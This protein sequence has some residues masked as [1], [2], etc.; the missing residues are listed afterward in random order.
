MELLLATA[1]VGKARE[2]EQMLAADF[3][4]RAV[5]PRIEETG[6]TFTDNAILKATALSLQDRQS[7]VIADDSGLEVDSL[8]GAPGIFSARYAG[9]NASD[10]DKV[11]KLLRELGGKH[12]RR[13]RFRCVIALAR[14]GK[15]VRT[16]EGAVAGVIVDLARGTNGFGYDPV[17]QPDGC[18]KT[19]AE[20]PS[21]VK[22][23]ISHRARAIEQ[24]RACLQTARA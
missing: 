15:L 10:A 5:D 8:G 4:V 22:N 16:F 6:K 11:A 23:R 9:A 14:D 2:F 7:L 17:F 13:A 1:N 24:L 19:F 20:L 18:D 21:E 12:D 3:V